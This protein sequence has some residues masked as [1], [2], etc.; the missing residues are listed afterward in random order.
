[1]EFPQIPDRPRWADRCKFP[2]GHGADRCACHRSH[3]KAAE[4]NLFV[5][6]RCGMVRNRGPFGPRVG[7]LQWPHRAQCRRSGSVVVGNILD[8]EQYNYGLDARAGEY[9]N[10]VPRAS[11]TPPRSCARR[12]R[13]R[14]RSQAC[15]SPPRP[16]WQRCRGSKRRRPCPAEA[17]TS[18][19]QELRLRCQT[20]MRT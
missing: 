1:V 13:A 10:L 12:C 2:V 6:A 14:R 5:A 8:K 17:W 15:S 11:S 4:I 7:L 3:R 9:G 16:W 19:V 20:S 18:S